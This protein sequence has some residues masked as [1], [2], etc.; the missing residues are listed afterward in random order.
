MW[1]LRSW[2]HWAGSRDVIGHSSIGLEHADAPP[3]TSAARNGHDINTTNDRPVESPEFRLQ[4]A[5]SELVVTAATTSSFIWRRC[6]IVVRESCLSACC[7]APDGPRRAEWTRA[8]ASAGGAARARRDV[9]SRR[10]DAGPRSCG[11]PHCRSRSFWRRVPGHR[12]RRADRRAQGRTCRWQRDNPDAAR[13][14]RQPERA[15]ALHAR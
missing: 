2:N 13:A 9:H 6:A 15:P 5:I 7:R 3:F 1:T 10:C 12:R 4:S 11:D 8:R 14:R